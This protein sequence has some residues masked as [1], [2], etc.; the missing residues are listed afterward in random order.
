MAN[1]MPDAAERHLGGYGVVLVGIDG[2]AVVGA[3][4]VDSAV[5]RDAVVSYVGEN[6][7]RWDHQFLNHPNGLVLAV[8]VDP[9]S[10]GDGIHACRKDYT[11]DTD[12]LAVRDGEVFVRLPGQTRPAT[13]YDIAQLEQRKARAPHTGAA[14][15]VSYDGMF[16]RVSLASVRDLIKSM[17]D[18]QADA[19]VENVPDVP[20]SPHSA[21]LMAMLEPSMSRPD[22]RTPDRFRAD[23][24]RW[25]HESRELLPDV[26]AE[27]VRHEL[28]RGRFLVRN[29]SDR[30][31]ESVRVE[32]MFPPGVFVLGAWDT[33]YCDHGGSFQP[34]QLLPG[35]PPKWGD[36]KPYG[37]DM[38]SMAIPSFSPPNTAKASLAIDVE[39]TEHGYV[40]SWFVGDLPPRGTARE[41]EVFAVFTDESKHVHHHSYQE[42]MTSE[43]GASWQV[44]A[45]GVDHVFQGELAIGCAQEPGAVMMWSRQQTP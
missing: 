15:S 33:D 26:T 23:V 7:P 40:V 25:A 28:A 13:S 32:I 21:R 30:Y 22:R 36:L 42:A 41:D 31:L 14:V 27:F 18:A 11:S 8:I 5:L 37:F 16:D 44:T 39:L 20:A 35:P 6:G 2:R 12:R 19:L 34:F 24:E 45:R 29:E 10:W 1:R 4:Q 17:I 9:P 38:G 3:E 43:V